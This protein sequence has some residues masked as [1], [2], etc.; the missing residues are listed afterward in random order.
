MYLVLRK[1]PKLLTTRLPKQKGWQAESFE[2]WVSD[3]S[4]E[5]VH[6]EDGDSYELETWLMY[7]FGSW[8][9]ASSKLNAGDSV[10][11]RKKAVDNLIELAFQVRSGADQVWL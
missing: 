2:E 1:I 9:S 10:K 6:F 5:E 4:S 7:I 3:L 11:A 8:L